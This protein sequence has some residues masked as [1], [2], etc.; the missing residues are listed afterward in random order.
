MKQVTIR[1]VLL[2]FYSHKKPRRATVHEFFRSSACA[3]QS[4]SSLLPPP[5]PST[6]MEERLQN[7][8]CSSGVTRRA[9]DVPARQGANT[10]LSRNPFH[11]EC[12]R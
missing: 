7:G 1:K 9:C 3:I 4:N 11:L 6:R 2:V 10:S 8:L 5:V 12:V